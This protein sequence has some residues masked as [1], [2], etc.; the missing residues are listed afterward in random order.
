MSKMINWF[1]PSETER[2]KQI[3]DLFSNTGGYESF[4]KLFKN[5]SQA[6]FL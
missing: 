4:W 5:L 6:E 3:C 1:T 2:N